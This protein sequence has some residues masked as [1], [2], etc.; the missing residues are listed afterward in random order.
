MFKRFASIVGTMAFLAAIAGTAILFRLS[1][2][3]DM[4]R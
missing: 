2:V 1:L 4:I 3:L